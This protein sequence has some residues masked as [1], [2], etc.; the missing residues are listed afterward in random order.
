MNKNEILT[1]WISV[2]AAIFAVILIYSYTQEKS[3]QISKTFGAQ[4]LVV[5][6]A[7]DINEMQTVQENMVELKQVPESFVQPGFVNQMEDIVGLVALAPISKGEQVLR[8]K[9]IKPGLETGLSLQVSP[10]KRAITLPVDEVRGVAH[11]I[12]PGDRVDLLVALDKSSGSRSGGQKRYIKTLLQDV[13]I[14]A[15]GI[16]ISN[17]LPRIHEEIG[18]EDFIKNLRTENKFSTITIESDPREV[19]NLVYILS[20]NPN[21]IFLSLRHPTDN[22]KFNLRPAELVHVLGQKTNLPARTPASR[23]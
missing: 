21:S 3:A 10:G 4:T 7:E 14:L 23:K 22:G 2:G 11:L 1:L 16:R 8:N 19:Q 18:G 20:T 9:I 15:T 13:I 5:V 12:K 17:E 6:A